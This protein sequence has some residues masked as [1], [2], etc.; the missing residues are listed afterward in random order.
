MKKFENFEI[1]NFE[2]L[3]LIF[4]HWNLNENARSVA[5]YG[6]APTSAAMI[7]VFADLDGVSN[8]AVRA[9]TFHVDDQAD[10][11]VLALVFRTIKPL[12]ARKA[13]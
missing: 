3:D 5:G 11:A 6:I 1:E 2:N 9:A 8:D 7:E 13:V 10:T 12:C 4:F